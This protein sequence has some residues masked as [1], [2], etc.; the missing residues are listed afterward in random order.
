MNGRTGVALVLAGWLA[1]AGCAVAPAPRGAGAPYPRGAA[2]DPTLESE[3]QRL[4]ARAIAR[5]EAQRERIER[6]GRRLLQTIPGSPDVQFVLV[7]GDPSVNAGATFG[8]VG[9]T[10]G[11]LD[12]IESDDEMAVVLGHELAHI[13]EGHVTRGMIGGIALNVLA[14]VLETQVPGAGQAAGGIGQLF[15][16]HYT[17]TQER[18][19]D[20]VGLEYAY[21]AGYD[22]RAAIDVM[23]RMAVEVPQTMTAGYFDTHPGSVERAMSAREQAR[24]LLALGPPPNR[25]QAVAAERAALAAEASRRDYEHAPRAAREPLPRPGS[26]A[27]R[28]DRREEPER[29]PASGGSCARADVYVD[30]ARDARSVSEK[31]ELY[32]RALRYCPDSRAARAAL[33]RLEESGDDLDVRRRAD[34]S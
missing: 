20:R 28:E 5:Q 22:P 15:L 8:Q 27:A 30:M 6:V 19:A 33:D 17:Q 23:E 34:D 32:E 4:R 12:F 31:R 1:L 11:M 24:E 16:N 29:R 26:L 2:G 7:A 3:Y 18:A 14:I 9:V 10:S 13:Q 21:R 25:E